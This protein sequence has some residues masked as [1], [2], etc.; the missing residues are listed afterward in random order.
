MRCV[1]LVSALI[2]LTVAHLSAETR[3]HRPVSVGK[4]YYIAFPKAAWGNQNVGVLINSPTAQ[5]V[6]VTYPTGQR[7][8][9][10]IKSPR[11]TTYF[12][13]TFRIVYKPEVLHAHEATRIVAH[14]PISLVGQFGIGG[15]SGTFTALPVASWGMEYYAVLPPEGV[16]SA[17]YYYP[18]IYSVPMITIIASRNGTIVSIVPNAPTA[19]GHAAGVPFMITLNAGDVYN[20]T[21]QG[22]PL[23]NPRVEDPCNAD[24]SGTHIT[25]NWPIGVMVAQTHSTWPCGDNECGDYAVEWLPP[26]AAWDSV[27][28]V[29][30]AVPR[31][32]GAVGEALK[33]VFAYDG[34]ELIV[35]D[36]Q[37]APRSIG[38]FAAGQ[39]LEYPSPIGQALIMQ[40]SHP[41]QIL[42]VTKKPESCFYGGGENWTLGM[43]MLVGANQWGDYVP[44]TAPIGSQAIGNICFRYAQRNNIRLNGKPLMTQFPIVKILPQGFATVPINVNAATYG[45]LSCDSGATAGG[46]VFGYGTLRYGPPDNGGGNHVQDPEVIKSF[47]HSI[48][49]NMNLASANDTTPP[50]CVVTYGCAS[51]TIDAVEDS[52]S[53]AYAGMGEAWIDHGTGADTSFNVQFD[54]VNAYAFGDAT[55]KFKITIENLLQTARGVVRVRDLAGNEFD[56]TLVYTPLNTVTAVPPRLTLAPAPVGDSTTDHIVLRNT[57][58]QPVT[59]TASR[60]QFGAKRNWSIVAPSPSSPFTIKPGDS[61]VFTLRHLSLIRKGY[62]IDEDTLLVTMCREFALATMSAAPK[63]PAINTTCFDFGTLTTD[64]LGQG[65]DSVASD[66]FSGGIWVQNIGADTLRITGAH[67]KAATGYEPGFP[68]SDFTLTGGY[69]QLATYTP[70]PTVDS[71]WVLAPGTKLGVSV[72]AHPH[73][74]GLRKAWIAFDNNA[75]GNVLDTACLSVNGVMHTI[76]ATGVDYGTTLYATTRDSFFVVRNTGTQVFDIVARGFYMSDNSDTSS[77]QFHNYLDSVTRTYIYY[78]TSLALDLRPGDTVRVPY[79]FVADTVGVRTCWLNVGNTTGS[80]AAITLQGRVVQPHVAGWSAC[81]PDTLHTGDNVML[82]V[83]VFNRG[84]DSLVLE[85]IEMSGPRAGEFRIVKTE[86]SHR[87]D[88][89]TVTNEPGLAGSPAPGVNG[90][91]AIVS[92]QWT[93]GSTAIPDDLLHVV[94]RDRLGRHA[95]DST[96]LGTHYGWSI[97]PYDTAFPIMRYPCETGIADAALLPGHAALWQN[98][99]NPFASSTAISYTLPAAQ[100]VQLRICTILGEPIA[101][102]TDAT[103]SAGTHTAIWNA[104]GARSGIYL[105]DFVSG[106]VHVSRA[107]VKIR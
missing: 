86:I 87:G 79:R 54:N 69:V 43:V 1:L 90:D 10:P 91:T 85:R 96:V 7:T 71:P 73:H 81:P 88:V 27:Y 67:L 29:T 19:M 57:G 59:F 17:Y 40:C 97:F 42:E 24:L 53:G 15:I 41:F 13:G 34:S 16:N 93:V 8:A 14:D 33:I 89:Q 64:T 103:E 72:K 48:G 94:G 18:T 100:R 38:T 6:D 44:F 2:A 68:E 50:H 106:G 23:A 63:V 74:S 26:V 30:P 95:A 56:T 99:P 52:L 37:S 70:L 21:T 83:L 35:D 84:D 51:W 12:P 105:V 11:S 36:G 66:S 60:L 45:E 62:A 65:G 25:S 55:A 4:E 5:S 101:T 76:T 107:I 46:T 22:D 104:R 98:Y 31:L 32:G 20:I 92:V 47:A 78:D 77:F 49:C 61:T 39:T 75:G 28:V 58:T 80:T 82:R 3:T 9:V 102:L